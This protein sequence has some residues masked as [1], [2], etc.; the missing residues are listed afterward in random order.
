MDESP[1]QVEDKIQLQGGDFTHGNGTGGESI[2]GEKFADE[3]FR[4]K[5]TK[6]AAERHPGVLEG[7]HVE[8]LNSQGKLEEVTR[9]FV[10][11]RIV[12]LF[13]CCQVV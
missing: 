12:S 3:N 13:D 11:F 6:S 7:K 9:C 4:V 1:T 8:M 5:H 10:W 2:Y